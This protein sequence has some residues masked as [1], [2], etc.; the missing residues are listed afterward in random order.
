MYNPK[1]QNLKTELKAFIPDYIP[2][3]GEVDAFLKPARPDGAAEELGLTVLD[4]PCLNQSKKSYL[5]LMIK[6]FYKG[7]RKL[8]QKHIH[9]ISNAHKKP[10]EI[11]SWIHDV[12]QLQKQKQPPNVFYSNKMPEVDTLMQ[13]FDDDTIN[14][15]DQFKQSSDMLLQFQESDIPL[16]VLTKSLCSV[17][18][19]PVYENNEQCN[20]I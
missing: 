16:D 13:N 11:L 12:E 3:I 2:T 4:E 6:Q 15:L 8:D 14:S 19:V 20:F 10:K 1:K 5:D 18:G 9:S 7:K 17:I